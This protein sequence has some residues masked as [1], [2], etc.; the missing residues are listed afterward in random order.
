MTLLLYV[1]AMCVKL[2]NTIVRIHQ[3][4]DLEKEWD[5]RQNCVDVTTQFYDEGAELF[6]MLREEIIYPEEI[7]VIL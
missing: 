3:Y 5:E 2:R 7:C 4:G 1:L 6:Q